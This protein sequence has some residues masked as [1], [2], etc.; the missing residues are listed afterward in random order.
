VITAVLD[1]DTLWPSVRRDC[2]LTLA[3]AGFFRP[4][5]SERTLVELGYAERA[6]L[7]SRG[8][9]NAEAAGRSIRLVLEMRRAFADAVVGEIHGATVP[10]VGLPDRDDEHVLAAARVAVADV[11][12]TANLRHFPVDLVGAYVTPLSPAAFMRDI[13]ALDPP[14]ALAA[15]EAMAHRRSATQVDALLA[16]L[17]STYAM[18][19]ACALLRGAR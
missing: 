19:E 18:D 9:T 11:L 5:W 14:R 7:V 17:E 16:K 13:V 1:T 3:Q 2:L 8:T 10:H 12:V 4:V 15:I 6:K